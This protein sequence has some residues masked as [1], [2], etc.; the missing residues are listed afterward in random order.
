MAIVEE[1]AGLAGGGDECVGDGL[2]GGEGEVVE[3]GVD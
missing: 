1:V 3:G 2:E